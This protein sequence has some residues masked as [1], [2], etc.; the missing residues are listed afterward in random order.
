MRNTKG[1]SVLNCTHVNT[2]KNLTF[3]FFSELLF[4]HTLFYI[5]TIG[6]YSVRTGTDENTK[7]KFDFFIFFE[8]FIFTYFILHTHIPGTLTYLL[9]YMIYNYLKH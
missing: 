4:L 1:Y 9:V 2:K 6:G 5:R 8:L 7:I 3:L